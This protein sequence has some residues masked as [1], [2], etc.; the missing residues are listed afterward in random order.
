MC[1]VMVSK[2]NKS[3]Y[4]V[5]SSCCVYRQV[6]DPRGHSNTLAVYIEGGNILTCS[7]VDF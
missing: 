1:K 4:G 6:M 5:D 7:I 2:G 3:R